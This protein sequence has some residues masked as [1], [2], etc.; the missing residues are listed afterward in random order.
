MRILLDTQA[1][2]HSWAGYEQYAW[3]MD[4]L[5]PLSKGG[6]NSFGGVGATLVDALDTLLIMGMDAEFKR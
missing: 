1:F 4:E 2:Q 3:G 6:R 5:M